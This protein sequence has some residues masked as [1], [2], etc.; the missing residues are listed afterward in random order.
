MPR[1]LLSTVATGVYLP[2]AIVIATRFEEALNNFL[3]CVS[4]SGR[5]RTCNSHD[6]A[7]LLDSLVRWSFGACLREMVALSNRSAQ[8]T[9]HLLFRRGD[10]A[11]YD[12]ADWDSPKRL[13]FGVAALAAGLCGCG[14]V[15]VSMSQIWWTG[16]LAA[17]I[18]GGGDIATELGFA[19]AALTYMPFKWLELKLDR[20]QIGY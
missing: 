18:D 15:V 16:P 1:F 12:I 5:Y 13:P 19:V 2:I 14:I 11:S 7:R 8:I 9:D 17:Q 6:T 4:G 20:R 10:F 3:S